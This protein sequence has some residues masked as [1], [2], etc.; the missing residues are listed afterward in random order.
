M[1]MRMVI[2]FLNLIYKL[3]FSTFSRV[4]L[5]YFIFYLS[6]YSMAHEEDIDNITNNITNNIIN[7]ITLND[8]DIKFFTIFLNKCGISCN[9]IHNLDNFFF[10]RDLL[11]SDERY[12]LIKDDIPTLRKYFSSSYMTSLQNTAEKTQRWPLINIVRQ[13]LKQLNYRLIPIRK[14]DGYTK[15][16]KKKFRRMFIIHKY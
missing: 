13:I 8:D 14:C 11:L 12:E 5:T 7:K 16:K 15:D 9:T 1:M 3:D 6:I 2:L 4:S 10:P